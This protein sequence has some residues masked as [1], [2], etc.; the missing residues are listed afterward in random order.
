MLSS[1]LA[2]LRRRLSLVF[3][4]GEP[5]FARMRPEDTFSMQSVLQLINESPDFLIDRNNTDFNELR[6]MYDMLSVAVADGVKPPPGAGP[7]AIKQYDSE[8]DQTARRLKIMWSGIHEGGAAFESRLEAKAQ[9][10]DFERKLLHVVRTKPPRK[11]NIFGIDD[12]ALVK[13]I[14][15]EQQQVASKNFMAK[16]LGNEQPAGTTSTTITLD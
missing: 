5:Q 4:F 2:E 13:K 7:A 10:K 8:V 1:K 3:V 12:E 15:E 16:F 11:D 6:A 14:K 9:L